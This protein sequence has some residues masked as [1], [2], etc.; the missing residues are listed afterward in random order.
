MKRII[1]RFGPNG[2]GLE[3][4]SPNTAAYNAYIGRQLSVGSQSVI[5][6][7]IIAEGWFLLF[8]FLILL[9]C[10]LEYYYKV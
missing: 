3:K 8:S 10:H 7:E 9:L 6:E 4:E 2:D 1:A 5:V